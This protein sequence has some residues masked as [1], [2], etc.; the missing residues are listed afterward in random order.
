MNNI[1]SFS[2]AVAAMLLAGHPGGLAQPPAE[3]P[4][5]APSRAPK[6]ERP[7]VLKELGARESH[8][9][10]GARWATGLLQEKLLRPAGRVDR[11]ARSNCQRFA[12]RLSGRLAEV[13]TC[14]DQLNGLE[15]LAMCQYLHRDL[16]GAR[17]TVDA[18]AKLRCDQPGKRGDGYVRSLALAERW[19]WPEVVASAA[20]AR[21]GAGSADGEKLALL[22]RLRA[23][24][25]RS[26]GAQ[27]L[28]SGVVV[29]SFDRGSVAAG[30]GLRMGD[31]IVNVGSRPVSDH[32]AVM[33][34]V[35]GASTRVVYLR[36]GK[37]R[38]GILKGPPKTLKVSGVP[39]E[40]LR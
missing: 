25:G 31:I 26:L 36:D 2:V 6:V 19:I 13:G 8:S 29:A 22:R 15:V 27:R 17:A 28:S 5:A 35:K 33:A 4:T 12:A 30:A 37:R 10:E 3:T 7:S 18:L 38:E 16:N 11:S 40:F 24:M 20:K 34:A 21:T 14:A 23:A 9:L 32:A 39:E 1:L